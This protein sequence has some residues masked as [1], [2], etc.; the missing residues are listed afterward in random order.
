MAVDVAAAA[1]AATERWNP[2][3]DRAFQVFAV[4]NTANNI[5]DAVYAVTLPLLV[6]DL[7]GSLA[8]M[9]L[10]AALSPVALVLG[11]VFGL[12]ADRWGPRVLVVPGLLVQLAAALVLNVG[13]F[14]LGAPIA[15]LF[16]TGALVQLGGGM[17]RSG[18]MSGIPSMWPENPARARGALSSCYVATTIVGPAMAAA[19]VNGV[20]YE[21]LLWFN[22]VT[23]VAPIVVWRMGIHPAPVAG[24]RPRSSPVRELVAG[25]RILQQSTQVFR[26]MLVVLPFDFVSSLGTV[27]LVMYYL[28]DRW[29]MSPAGVSAVLLAANAGALVGSFV[30]A[31]RDHWP[32]RPLLVVGIVGVAVCL[33]VMPVPALPVLL[34]AFVVYSVL[35]S[36][37]AVAT[38]MLLY[39]AIPA[40]AIG[41][42]NGFWRLVHGIPQLLAPLF[43]AALG[44]H[45][46]VG[47]TFVVLGAIG[48]LSVVWLAAS[49][50]ELADRPN[51]AVT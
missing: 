15:L 17:Y 12:A 21:A 51:E 5:G 14:V 18:W 26:V 20:G 47:T 41:R 35:D 19:L 13:A 23:F 25:W 2:W 39:R 24:E 11:P 32:L 16:V 1:P 9:S 34:V 45:V 27:T 33:A 3:R 36:G 48:G 40:D 37:L 6:F 7:T 22:L 8:L 46:G 29:D 30:A 43:I 44:R 38:E 28:R 42:S 31:E 50:R 10:L 4:G 49:W